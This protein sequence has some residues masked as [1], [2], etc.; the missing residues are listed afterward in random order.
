MPILTLP[1]SIVPQSFTKTMRR[2]AS[3]KQ[4]VVWTASLLIQ[5]ATVQAD[6]V[7]QGLFEG[8]TSVGSP[9]LSGT[10]T[11]DAAQQQYTL[12][13][14]GTN[15]WFGRDEFH[16]VWKKLQG[17]FIL[18]ARVELQGKGVD[19]H[20]KLGWMVRS[21]L[22]PE[23]PYADAAIHG[24]GLTA[25]QFRRT[26][27][28]NTEQVKSALTAPEV[29][30]FSRRGNT[31]T[32]SVARFGEPFTTSA[33][34]LDLGDEV[35]AGLFICS[36]NGAV[37]E[38]GTFREVRITKP[39]KVGFTPYR[40]YIGSQLEILEVAS[41]HPEIV[42]ASRDPFEAPNWTPDGKALIYNGSG[43]STNSG[44]L[45]RFD[46][47]KHQPTLIDTAFA[48][49]N[50]NDHVLSFDGTLLGIS[51]RS[52]NHGNQSTVFSVP[53]QGG[54]PQAITP[55]LGPSSFHG[56][57][58]DGKFMLYTGGRNQKLDIY[59]IPSKGGEEVRLT[60]SPGL[61]DGSEYTPDGKTIY[62]NSSRT[63]RMQIWR[64]KPD[65]TGQEQVTNDEF[66]NWFPHV[67]PDGQWIVFISFP[68]EI[69]ATDH[70]YYK[71]VYLRLLPIG[72]GKPKVIAYV[73]GG[74]G[75]LNVPSWSPDSKRLA[76][77]SNN[78]L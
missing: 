64:M 6:E 72:G 8:Q 34:N 10:S 27:G 54:V 32:L 75:T 13:G 42:H 17:D 52:T 65:G 30:E 35:F 19:P 58:P 37:S 16:F 47:E 63:G 45:F 21:S 14:S 66:N 50:N 76:F 39:A 18:R 55:A 5:F 2:Q 62:F 11:Y 59:R 29:V 53:V 60:D 22:D 48:N 31:Y 12:T 40:D 20:R 78:D 46:L 44:R 69:E 43:R 7:P 26:K 67:S 49:H 9:K 23:A 1:D 41:G 77:V 28:A 61:N 33:T 51:H 36:H 68:K 73:Y 38:T 25:L 3:I 71:N 74:Q 56:W 70:P 57:S 15:M 24:D 4:F